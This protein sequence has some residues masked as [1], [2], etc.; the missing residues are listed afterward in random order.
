MDP[1]QIAAVQAWTVKEPQSSIFR[2]DQ[3]IG[4]ISQNRQGLRFRCFLCMYRFILSDVA[5]PGM[6]PIRAVV[7]LT[8]LNPDTIRAWERRYRAIEPA[9]SDGGTRQFSE[10]D[11][12]RLIC[13]KELRERGYA[14]PTLAKLPTSELTTMRHGQKP[15]AQTARPTQPPL[16]SEQQAYLDAI[17]DLDVGAALARLKEMSDELGNLELILG[18]A[19]PIMWE[20]GRRWSEGTL[21]TAP[22]HLVRAQLKSLMTSR[23]EQIDTA[24]GGTASLVHDASR[25][26][27]RVRHS[28]G[29][30]PCERSRLRRALPGAG[31]PDGRHHL[32]CRAQQRRYSGLIGGPAH[33]RG[34]NEANGTPRRHRFTQRSNLDWLPAGP[35]T[36]LPSPESHLHQLNRG[37]PKGGRLAPG[38]PGRL[39]DGVRESRKPL[40]DSL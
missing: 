10:E 6:L 38:G 7:A 5:K 25:P 36:R 23:L 1:V 27:S 15:A 22:E 20:V 2:N 28:R 3:L 12:T 30:G 24:P 34:R 40:C 8:G 11:V 32:E 14:L 29:L 19:I 26:A 4:E 16:S 33:E 18:V 21:G 37:L 31:P 17:E 13:L 35:P 39:K 9:R